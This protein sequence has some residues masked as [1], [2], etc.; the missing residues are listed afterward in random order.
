M[1]KPVAVILTVLTL[2]FTLFSVNAF[3]A[4]D[5][6][7]Y[8]S[9]LFPMSVVYISRTNTRLNKSLS[10]EKNG[11]HGDFA[12]DL[13]GSDTA[14]EAPFTGK[15]LFIDKG[16]EHAVFFQS[17]DKVYLPDGRLDYLTVMFVHDDDVSNLKVGQV[18]KQGQ[19]LYDQGTFGRGR[20]GCFGR[21]VHIEAAVGKL[22]IS[23]KNTVGKNIALIRNK[24]AGVQLFDCFYLQAGTKRQKDCDNKSIASKFTW[25]TMVSM[26]KTAVT[27][28]AA[29]YTGKN[30]DVNGLVT[31]K[32]GKTQLKA[33]RD[34]TV[35]VANVKNVGRYD[36]TVTGIGQ[37]AGT[38]KTTV[39]VT[40]KTAAISN[41]YAIKLLH[42]VCV[43]WN[44]VSGVSGYKVQI[45]PKKDFSVVHTSK[46]DS[47]VTSRSYADT[48]WGAVKSGQTYY[49]RVCTYTKVS[50][51]GKTVEICSPW[52]KVKTI[53][54]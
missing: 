34:Y 12:W 13:I 23:T 47:S 18:I 24:N 32:N 46:V 40:P 50:Y 45:S 19:H 22:A 39:T 10:V 52:S 21:H 31:V 54:F 29:V 48:S 1:K 26:S 43:S 14:L 53:R 6:P 16:N 44:K 2:F 28:G 7:T 38:V 11:G 41:L 4:S 36:V 5:S 27:G 33:G 8:E 3:A 17:C 35:S 20:K 42:R 30:I 15:V 51:G 37:Y 9:A 25:K 49:L